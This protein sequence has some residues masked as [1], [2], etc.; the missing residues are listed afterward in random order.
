MWCIGKITA[1]FIAQMESILHLYSLKANPLCPLVC[2]DEKSYQLLG[3]TLCPVPMKPGKVRKESEK[4]KRHGTVQILVAFLPFWGLR[5]VWV[6]PTRRAWDF[7]Y[8]MK[9]FME[10]FLPSVLPQ[11]KTIR[12]VC[13]NLNTH[14][15]ASFYKT[16][17][18]AQAF[19]LA[20]NIQF[21]F[22]PVNASWLNMAEME[23]HGL[24]VQC[25]NRR[26]GSQKLVHTEVQHIVKERNDKRIKVNWQFDLTAARQKFGRG[27]GKLHY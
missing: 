10:E 17:S 9:V 3:H 13:D 7:A 14:T 20:Q 18:P 5:F 6:S 1:E 15:A 19:E 22:T 4:Y 23:I 25:L 2:F 24:S 12:L 8:F 11:A 26:L 16:F 27:Y 21:H